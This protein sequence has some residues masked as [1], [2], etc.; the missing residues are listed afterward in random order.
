MTALYVY[1]MLIQA[2]GKC[3]SSKALLSLLYT[4]L[5]ATVHTTSLSIR[6]VY[7]SPQLRS[8][9]LGDILALRVLVEG[10]TGVYCMYMFANCILRHRESE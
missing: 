5:L 10:E 3:L 6:L 7:V 2:T 9:N 4:F 1:G 8:L